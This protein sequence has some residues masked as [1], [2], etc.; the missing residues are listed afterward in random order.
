M[1]CRN[2]A[3]R[4]FDDIM[5]YQEPKTIQ[6][7]ALPSKKCILSSALQVREVQILYSYIQ[8]F[9]AQFLQ[10]LPYA[11]SVSPGTSLRTLD[12]SQP[13]LDSPPLPPCQSRQD[14][15]VS[16]RS[17]HRKLEGTYLISPRGEFTLSQQYMCGGHSPFTI[18][19]RPCR[20][21]QCD[22]SRDE[23]FLGIYR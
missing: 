6:D 19:S 11:L 12:L 21:I 8:S 15:T 1:K 23:P 16:L 5:E 22:A 7:L 4:L 13:P 20:G 3:R 2:R 18:V 9:L 10:L 17:N 14:G